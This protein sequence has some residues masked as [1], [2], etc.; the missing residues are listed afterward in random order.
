MLKKSNS[1]RANG[2]FL[3]ATLS[4]PL[5]ELIDKYSNWA[6]L[7]KV[8]GLV[9]QK[10]LKR[11]EFICMIVSKA[12]HLHI[13]RVSCRGGVSQVQWTLPLAARSSYVPS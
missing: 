10:N 13:S 12:K 11:H 7:H 5:Y 3:K 9:I 4:Y 8:L 6:C 1:K 2:V